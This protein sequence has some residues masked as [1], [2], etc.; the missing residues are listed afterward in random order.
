MNAAGNANNDFN[1]VS[2]LISLFINGS[3]ET[4]VTPVANITSF[5]PDFLQVDYIG[6][7]RDINDLW[8]QS[9]SCNASY[10]DFGSLQTCAAS[11]VS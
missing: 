1:F 9:W 4:A 8:Y 11:P 5:S 7:V 2:S 10:A 3:N 6:A